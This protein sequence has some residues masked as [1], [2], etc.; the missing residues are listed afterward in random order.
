MR[1]CIRYSESFKLS[2]LRALESGEVSS[3]FE[4]EVRFGIRGNGTVRRWVLKY[5][6]EHLLGKLIR[7]ETVKETNELKELRERVKV[8]EKALSTKTIDHLMAESY[9][10]L[11]CKVGNIS[12]VEEFK[13]KHSGKL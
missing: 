5:G 12:D 13:K 11:A 9:L 3:P 4:A 7:V 10:K 8:L 2:V 6:K 1:T